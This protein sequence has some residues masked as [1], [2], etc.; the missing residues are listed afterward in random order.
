MSETVVRIAGR[1]DG[2]TDAGTYVALA[3][4]GDTVENG[5]IV[6][7]GPGYQDPPCRHFPQCGGCQLQHLTDDAY[8][9]YCADRI[10]GALAQKGI[11]TDI[12][13]AHLSPP[14]TRRRADLKALKLGRKLLLG[15]TREQSHQIVDMSECHVLVPELLALIGPIRTLLG[16]LLPPRRAGRVQMTLTD[17]GIDLLLGG[18]ETEGLAAAEALP[19]FAEKH[20][21]AR[22]SI[23]DGY[24]AEPRYEPQPVTI[25]LS[26]VAVPFPQGGF[27][28]A[29][30]DGEAALVSGVGAALE[31]QGPRRLDLFAGLGTFA[32]A[33]NGAV[34]AAEAGRDTILSLMQAARRA[35]RPVEAVHRDLYRR[36]YD[37]KEL[38]AFDAV[39]LDPPRA[40]AEAQCAQ[41]AASS[42]PAIAYV[43]CNPGTFARD[44]AVLVAGGYSLDWVQPVG[45][46]RWSTHVELVSRLTR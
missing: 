5:E 19:A 40:G 26:G 35:G 23:D 24:G 17:Q 33:Q 45:Q 46:F 9:D 2:L 25:T 14:Q 21:L 37:A 13:R 32:L 42:V 16:D 29:T 36:P 39:I 43:S 22:L 18:I 11:A 7:R 28:Q 30:A 1:G 8:A 15:F 34:E 10:A 41:L 27:L 38:A 44:A 6:T 20:G 12:R 31:G 4:P 3:A